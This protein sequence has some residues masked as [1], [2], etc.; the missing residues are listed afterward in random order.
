MSFFIFFFTMYEVNTHKNECNSAF[1]NTKVAGDNKLKKRN[2]N[3]RD[4]NTSDS[5]TNNEKYDL[6][7]KLNMDYEYHWMNF[8]ENKEKL[9]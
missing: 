6:K 1:S 9:K 3:Q 4:Y 7:C 5:F 8:I 2:F